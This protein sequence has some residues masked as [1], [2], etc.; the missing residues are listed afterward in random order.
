VT[1][2]AIRDIAAHFRAK[3]DA[4]HA[5]LSR[6]TELD[7]AR[8]PRPKAWSR[9]EIIGH[10]VDSASNN[11]QR[12]VRARFQD[13]LVFGGY[14]QDDWV[15][16]QHYQDERWSDLLALWRAFNLH[17]AH[18]M[19]TTP[20]HDLLRPRAR[21][22]L[23]QIAWKPVSASDVVTLEWFMI[24]YVGHFEH[25]VAQALRSEARK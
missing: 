24:D 22:N 15:T 2:Q 17:L 8:R 19:E 20:E 11:H 23:H 21:H 25:H 7:S 4:A 1:T 3:L 6:V 18:V 10:L 9:K 5:E 14:E 12:F 16:A 13:D